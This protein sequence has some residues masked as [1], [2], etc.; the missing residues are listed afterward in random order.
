MNTLLKDAKRIAD[1]IDR[2]QPNTSVAFIIRRLASELQLQR[3]HY[4]QAIGLGKGTAESGG[5]GA[6]N[7]NPNRQP[8]VT[9]ADQ[10]GPRTGK[11]QGEA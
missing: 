5:S 9:A 8:G 2:I 3:K 1:E 6:P 10:S 7:R 4:E 11:S